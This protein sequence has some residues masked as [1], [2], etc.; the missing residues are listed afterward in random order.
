MEQDSTPTEGETPEAAAEEGST[1]TP[2]QGKT[3][4][5]DYVRQLRSEAAANRK[6]RQE[7]EAKIAEYENANKSELE[8]LA[9]KLT[10]AE[11]D[12]AEAEARL[13]R[14][15][16][17]AE[18]QVPA[19]ALDLLT[20]N[21][22]EELEARADKLLELVKNKAPAVEFDGGTRDPAPEPK[23]PEEAH[24]DFVAALLTGTNR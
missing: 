12:K 22:R 9:G 5:A 21:T 2:T 6:A 18:K 19:D 16:V 23:S 8:K 13:L 20:G 10:K 17:A 15:E 3:F 11:R 14:Y 1:P 4:D 24:S 7:A